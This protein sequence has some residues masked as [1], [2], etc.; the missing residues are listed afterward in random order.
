MAIAKTPVREPSLTDR[1]AHGFALMV[2][3]GLAGK[4]VSIVSQVILAWLLAPEIWGLIGLTYTLTFFGDQIRS[5]GIQQVLVH[6]HK[7]YRKWA[8]AAFWMSTTTAACGAIVVVLAARPV[9]MLYGEPALVGLVLVLALKTQIHGLST[10]PEARLQIDL[11]FGTLAAAALLLV[12]VQA[13][14]TVLFAWW[15]FGAYSFVWPQVIAHAVRT[16]AFWWITRPPV[17][18]SLEVRRWRYMFGDAAKNFWALMLQQ[19]SWQA[20]AIVLGLLETKEAVGIYFFGVA[21]GSQTLRYLTINLASVVFPALSKLQDDVVRQSSAFLRACRLLALVAIPLC[22][23]QAALAPA[24]VRLFLDDKWIP[25][26]PVIQLLSIGAAARV[27]SAPSLSMVQ[28]QGRFGAFFL[29]SL[30]SAVAMVGIVFVCALIG[31]VVL[32]CA[33]VA[34]CSMIV[35]PIQGYVAIHPAQ[36]RWREVARIYAS[37]GLAAGVAIGGGMLLGRLVPNVAG[38]DVL[39]AVV[40]VVVTAAVYPLLIG[41]ISRNDV[42]ELRARFAGLLSRRIG[43]PAAT[44]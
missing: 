20:A 19:V 4:L 11:R 39:E 36:G 43:R 5:M 6:R 3:Q 9:A 31:D 40:I 8:N 26:I 25:S 37:P 28:A 7:R 13:V 24:F 35:S 22:F 21:V 18:W 1:T 23:L 16:A 32:V 33:G 41:V 27:T 30:A 2:G 17:R 14:L 10:V 38:A 12:I 34:L 42:R 44:E 29:L 15:G